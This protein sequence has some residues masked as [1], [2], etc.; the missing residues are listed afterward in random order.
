MRHP[1]RRALALRLTEP[2]G[3]RYENRMVFLR[4]EAPR[5]IEIEHGSDKDN[6]PARFHVT[7]TFDAQGDGKTVLTMAYCSRLRNS[8]TPAS[9]RRGGARLSD[10]RQTRA[11]PWR[12]LSPRRLHMNSVPIPFPF[13][14]G[15]FERA[16]WAYAIALRRHLVR[17]AWSHAHP[18]P[19]TRR[20][21]GSCRGL[22]RRG[23]DSEYRFMTAKC[24][25][26]DATFRT[27]ALTKS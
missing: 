4:V 8:A 2:D 17:I 11:S 24:N 5:L 15:A 23:L 10:P 19:V 18:P 27:M 1:R 14:G 22:V 16:L 6:D 7:V 13:W 26:C 3:T 25:H 20:Q 9:V 12:E 21:N